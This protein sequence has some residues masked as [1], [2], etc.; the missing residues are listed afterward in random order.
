MAMQGKKAAEF[1]WGKKIRESE[2]G[3][4]KYIL[5]G[6]EY[7]MKYQVSGENI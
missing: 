2:D 6:T 1:D 7:F 3:E 4:F 5:D